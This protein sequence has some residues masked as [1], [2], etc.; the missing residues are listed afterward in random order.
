MQA[1]LDAGRSP[2]RLRHGSALGYLR[3][4]TGSDGAV[5]YSPTSAQSPV[6]VTAQALTALSGRPF[7][8]R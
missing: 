3:G 2:A 1:L 7:P 5:H 4:L 6:W 8:I